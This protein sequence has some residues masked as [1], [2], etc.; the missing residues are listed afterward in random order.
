MTPLQK[1]AEFA[2]QY[3]DDAETKVGAMLLLPEAEPFFGANRFSRQMKDCF[4]LSTLRGPSKHFY[5]EHAE[6]RVLADVAAMGKRAEG[7]TLYVTLF[8]CAACARAIV[9][10]GIRRVVTTEPDLRHPRWGAD[11]GA[12]RVIFAAHGTRVSFAKC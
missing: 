10:A 4:P 2:A 5:I 11:W 3:S 6:R 12:A 9:R 1:A 7:G 8:P